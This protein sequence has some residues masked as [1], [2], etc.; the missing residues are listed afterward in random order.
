MS[1]RD[2]LEDLLL[3]ARVDA[4][5]TDETADD[6][7]AAGWRPPAR[8]ITEPDDLDAL[9]S[10]SIIVDHGSPRDAYSKGLR[11]G[12][13]VTGSSLLATARE[14]LMWGEGRVTVV[15]ISTKEPTRD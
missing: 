8:E 1:D 5:T 15:H 13:Y 9:P 11:D 3:N 14:V 4:K 6:I 12:W 7:L 10:G 2:I